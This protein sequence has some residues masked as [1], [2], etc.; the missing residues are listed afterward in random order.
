MRL[1]FY[2]TDEVFVKF[3]FL[4][5]LNKYFLGLVDDD[6]KTS[7]A[8]TTKKKKKVTFKKVKI[9][10]QANNFQNKFQKKKKRRKKKISQPELENGE[11]APPPIVFS[12]RGKFHDEQTHLKLAQQRGTYGILL[13]N[14]F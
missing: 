9:V 5:Q 12:G 11:E 14:L 2:Q 1:E 7:E 4:K 6:E 3:I 13:P 8:S 10:N